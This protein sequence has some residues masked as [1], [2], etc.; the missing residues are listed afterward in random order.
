MVSGTDDCDP[1]SDRRGT[2]LMGEA[3]HQ[4]GPGRRAGGFMWL[5]LWWA[6]ARRGGSHRSPGEAGVPSAGS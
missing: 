4:A 5:D 2:V 1:G 3:A 6:I